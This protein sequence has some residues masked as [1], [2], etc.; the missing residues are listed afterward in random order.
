MRTAFILSVAFG[1]L[2]WAQTSDPPTYR[3]QV[4]AILERRC[5]GCHN[6]GG[7]GRLPLDTYAQA[8]AFWQEIRNTSNNKQM[9]PLFAVP[10]YGSFLN[11]SG[12]TLEE[13]ETLLRWTD[14]GEPLGT[15][16]AKPARNWA[17]VTWTKGK[18]DLVITTPL[19]QVAA[20]GPR[21][22]RCFALTSGAVSA[23][24]VGAI[25]V[26]PGNR[27]AVYQ[28]RVFA[29]LGVRQGAVPDCNHEE[30]G[31]SRMRLGEWTP[32]H[33]VIPLPAGLGRP[34][35]AKALLLVEVTYQP[36]GFPTTDATR[37]GLYFRA[38]MRHLR[39]LAI[40]TRNL[41]IP[42]GEWNAAAHANWTAAEDL[43][44]VSIAP[45]MHALGKEM[46]VLATR[47]GGS[48]ET[49]LWVRDYDERRQKAYV[50]EK[51]LFLPKGTQVEVQGLFNNSESN[52]RLPGGSTG[53]VAWGTAP[54]KEMLTAYIEY[55]AGTPQR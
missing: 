6:R 30:N 8:Q 10:G 25:E 15:G 33:G 38:A 23:K 14:A 4:Q 48:Q 39:T 21:Q 26:L 17:P 42:K 37:V 28:V 1:S 46:R 16:A 47:P 12:L 45:H 9:P 55:V 40:E 24:D 34:L 7:V 11:E 35:P 41:A 3:G 54:D 51:P 49:L 43:T 50:F 53:A 52:I 36:S 27:A 19:T 44:I 13:I 20:T 29:A 31:E 5:V 22:T 2:V 18:P 32:N